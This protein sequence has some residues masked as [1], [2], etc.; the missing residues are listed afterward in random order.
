MAQ[1][2]GPDEERRKRSWFTHDLVGEGGGQRVHTL[3]HGGAPGYTETARMLAESALSLAFDDGPMT[4]GQ[5]TPVAAM[6]E[7]LLARLKTAGMSFTVV[8]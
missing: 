5:V 3:V 4:A 1:G 7:D 6:G 8:D 2:S